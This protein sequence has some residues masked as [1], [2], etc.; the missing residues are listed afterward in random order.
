MHIESKLSGH[1]TDDQLI[2]HL[3][4]VGPGDGHMNVCG[5]CQARLKAMQQRR[6]A[7]D[8]HTS[9]DED[10][11]FEFLA[12]QRRSIYAKAAAPV[13]WWSMLPARRW[14]PVVAMTTLLAGSVFLYEANQ[15]HYTNEQLTD[16]QLAQQVSQMAADPEP[17]P[18]APLQAL[19]EE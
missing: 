8:R 9:A 17:Q 2:A 15:H 16:A 13:R 18:T 4:S 19:F 1:W 3:Y 7:I 14:V 6:T 5:E 11:T 12:A 10:V